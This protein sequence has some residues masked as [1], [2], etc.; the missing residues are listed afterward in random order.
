MFDGPCAW[1]TSRFNFEVKYRRG[2]ANANADGLSRLPIPSEENYDNHLEKVDQLEQYLTLAS[3]DNSPRRLSLTQ[4]NMVA[5]QG[6]DREIQHIRKILTSRTVSSRDDPIRRA[7]SIAS[8]QLVLHKGATDSYQVVVPFH[9]RERVLSTHHD[10]FGHLGR[11]RT[12]NLLSERYYWVNMH[13]DVRRWVQSCLTCAKVK[14]AQP[15]HNGLLEHVEAQYP[16]EVVGVDLMGPF[17]TTKTGYKYVMV[18]V[19]LF[20]NW[21]EA[22]PLRDLSAE[23]AAS[24]FFDT[25][26]S[27][28]GCPSSVLSD[29]GTNFNSELFR[30]LCKRCAIK[31]IYTSSKH[32]QTNG[33]AERLIRYMTNALAM[34]VAHDQMDW[35]KHVPG[36]RFAY[37]TTMNEKSMETPFFLLYGRDAVLTGDLLFDK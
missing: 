26:V 11:D 16:F 20:T 3:L 33:K 17:K 34:V 31:N 13:R 5:E 9:L 8:N 27:R 14:P 28:H 4:I 6:K 10:L 12:Y 23:E 36:A 22:V 7:F 35:D 32:P 25:I 30:H 18:F 15:K 1:P 2:K 19:D 37:R 24:A 21:V 29:L